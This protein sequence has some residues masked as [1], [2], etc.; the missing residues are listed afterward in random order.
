MG[1]EF[2]GQSAHS[3][4][5]FGDT[6]D[7]WWHEDQVRLIAS[8]WH[9]NEIKKVLDV[10]CGV[11]H[12]ARLL[13]RVLPRTEF[14]GVDRE[15]IWIAKA[16][17][18]AR[19][20]SVAERFRFHV[21]T[22]ET[23]PFRDGTFDLVTCQ[24]LL[25][26]VPDPRAALA[27]MVRVAK[28][29]A[30]VAVAEPTNLVGPFI[31][32]IVLGDSPERVARLLA[33]QLTCQRGKAALG[34]GDEMIG[35]S[36]PRLLAEAGLRGIELRLNDKAAPMRPPYDSA[37]ERAAMEQVL[38]FC[39]RGLWIATREVMQRRYLA[40][41]GGEVEFDRLWAE[42]LDQQR[43][44]VEAIRAGLYVRAGG[45]LF[46]LAWGRKDVNG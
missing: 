30:L 21:G 1:N 24:T 40:G 29:G 38:D 25:M 8:S 45:G 6:R 28:P 22:V 9:P 12:W 17:E 5:Y 14:T 37:E 10:G 41:G 11:G 15:P 23:L 19:A 4:E 3:A 26:H 13:A 42:A 43:R 39:E 36:L 34:D 32:S 7:Y 16:A 31:D 20:G 46:Y 2:K 44:V 18:R 27:E 33:F 35:E